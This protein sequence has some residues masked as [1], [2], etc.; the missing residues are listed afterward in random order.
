MPISPVLEMQKRSGAITSEAH[1][2]ELPDVYSSVG[3]EYEAIT[4]RA[5]LIDRSHIGRLKLTGVDCLDLLNRLSTNNLEL[6]TESWQGMGTVLT[7]SKGRIIDLLTVLRLDDDLLVL[8]GPGTRQKVA[9]W[10]EF[11]TFVE[12]V[13]VADETEVTAMFSVVGPKAAQVVGDVFNAEIANLG[14]LQSR[15]ISL[16]GNRLLV[17]RTDSLGL[18]GYD[19]F[20]AS[21]IAQKL[22]TQLLEAG[23]SRNMKPVGM[24]AVETVRIERGVAFEGTELTEEYNPLE[25]NLR[26]HISFNKGCYIGQEVVARLDTYEK[27]QKYLV[28]LSWESGDAP[29]P[30]ARVTLNGKRVGSVT[31]AVWSEALGK[32]I[33]LGFVRKAQAEP[34][35]QLIVESGNGELAATVE[36]LPFG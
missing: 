21:E 7:N 2:W 34:G 32:G 29:T 25:A 23:V 17:A 14:M 11:Y 20:V 27:V 1:G 5:G 19:L 13:S 31:S 36:E 35:N 18:L 4:Q 30:G 6:L 15:R 10:I 3:E 8:T 12:D 24:S 28:G 16:G 9:D 26:E 33:A 22:W